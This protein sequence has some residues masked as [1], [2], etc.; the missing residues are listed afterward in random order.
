MKQIAYYTDEH[1][2]AF[3]SNP[4]L[5]NEYRIIRENLEKK[6]YV[7]LN[8]NTGEFSNS[9]GDEDMLKGVSDLDSLIEDFQHA[10]GWKLI[11]YT[12][13]SDETFEFNGLMK[14][15]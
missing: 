3:Y 8:L 10:P 14:I 2:K 13:L 5:A 12:C 6:K 1:R 11:E 7:W 9:W 4:T 15:R